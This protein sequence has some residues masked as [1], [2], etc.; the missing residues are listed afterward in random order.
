M[1]I[2][3]DWENRRV[4]STASILDIVAH[5]DTLRALEETSIGMLYPPIISYK[6]LDLG[7]GAMFVGLDYINGYE[8]MFPD[9]G[10][11][12]IIG[13]VGADIVP[14]AGVFVDRTKAAAFATVAGSGGGG[15]SAEAIAEAVM[16]SQIE[17]GLEMVEAL[18]LIAST[19]AGKISGAAGPTLVFRAA[20]SDHK[21]RLTVTADNDGN[22]T[23]VATDTSA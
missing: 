3:V 18:R 2:S 13:N 12:T 19:L 8:L 14:V 21:T 23:T 11:Y 20:V 5:H 4:L 1:A 9:P 17:P 6:I 10:N 16:A 22:R 15:A 7:G